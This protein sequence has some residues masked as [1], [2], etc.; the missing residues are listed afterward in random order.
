M[1]QKT[2]IFIM[3]LVAAI[4]QEA[5]MVNFFPALMVPDVLL[6]VVALWTARI[7]F[8]KTWPRAILAGL[9]LDLIFFWPPG[10][11]IISLVVVSYLVSFLAKRFLISQKGWKFIFLVILTVISTIILHLIYYLV[12]TTLLLSENYMKMGA[13]SIFSIGIIYKIMANLVI[14]FVVYWPVKKVEDF[15]SMFNQSVISTKR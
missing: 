7:G 12:S 13:E 10:V 1:F 8:E 5:A 3:I 14:L 4:F 6:V 2:I 11:N 15:L 9:M